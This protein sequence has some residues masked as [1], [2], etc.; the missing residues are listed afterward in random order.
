M[1]APT[2]SV[3]ELGKFLRGLRPNNKPT[4]REVSGRTGLSESFLGKLER[5]EYETLLLETMRQ[6]AKGYG[7]P[8]EKLLAVS[9]Y[10]N[11]EEP[12]L[13]DLDV[14]L[15]T[16]FGL[17]EKGIQEAEQ[18]LEYVQEKHGKTKRK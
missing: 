8:L 15:R 9:G 12:P 10:V 6:V 18:F 2:M 3:R 5:G 16:K 17:T 13:P 14:Y 7:M 11:W 4:L 1:R